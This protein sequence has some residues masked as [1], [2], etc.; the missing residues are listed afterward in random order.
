MPTLNPEQRQAL[1]RV[2]NA[3]ARTVVLTNRGELAS[4]QGLL[5]YL[6]PCVGPA[7]LQDLPVLDAVGL[8]L[9]VSHC[10]VLVILEA[11]YWL[12]DVM[13]NRVAH[14]VQKGSTSWGAYTPHKHLALKIRINVGYH[15][16][17]PTLEDLGR[18]SG[19]EETP[20]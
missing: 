4:A 6:R 2:A 18:A 10:P 16:P 3:R 17:T 20:C 13:R 11:L 14:A 12:E 19:Q 15:L 7:A 5:R 1:T 9:R 8:T